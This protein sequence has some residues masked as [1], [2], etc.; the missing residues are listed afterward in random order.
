MA[1]TLLQLFAR[2]PRA[3]RVKTRLIPTLG[4]E[5]ALAVYRHCLHHNWSV[6]QASGFDYQLWMSDHDPDNEL[7]AAAIHLQQGDD[8]GQRMCHAMQQGL[9]SHRQVI[10]IGSDCL[11]ISTG[12]LARV[13]A[14]LESHHL[15][16]VPA[17]D[18]GYV[19]IAARHSIAQA[20]FDDIDWGSDR[21]LEQTLRQV[22]A[23]GLDAYLFDP[24]RDIDRVDDLQHYPALHQYL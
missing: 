6:L 8:L 17:L 23:V 3:G 2:P 9:L 5:R 11:D 21:V 1:D 10:L 19:L 15:V 14:Q 12:L 13:N 4:R 24:L 18:G 20:L 16:I 7:N 22:E